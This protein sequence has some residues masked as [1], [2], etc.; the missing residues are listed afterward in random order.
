MEAGAGGLQRAG[1]DP[2]G[3]FFPADYLGSA[4]CVWWLEAELAN[5]LAAALDYYL[6]TDGTV[7]WTYVSPPLV[8][9]A[10]G[11]RT[12]QYRT[13]HDQPVTDASGTSALSYED[14][15][16]VIAD[17][18]DIPKHPNQRFTAAY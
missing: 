15:A 11:T 12:G 4:D 1:R 8:N 3:E 18:I 10:P 16:V 13:G 6:A 7:T 5:A 14:L 17:E 9:F 2:G